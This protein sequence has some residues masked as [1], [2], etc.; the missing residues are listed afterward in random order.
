MRPALAP[1]AAADVVAAAAIA[2]GAP[3][4]DVCAAAAASVCLYTA[5][6]IQNDLFD[7]DRDKTLHPDRP[8][9]VDP[10]LA[11]KAFLL[12][13]VLIGVGMSLAIQ[14]GAALPAAIVVVLA[15]AYN[16]G[17]KKT[18]PADAITI[19][20]ARA[21]NLWIGLMVAGGGIQLTYMAGYLLFIG[22]ITSTSRAEDREPPPTRRLML[23][24]SLLPIALGV[25][26][27]ASLA[28]ESRA[29]FLL[30]G[31]VLVALFLRAF[32]D[33][34]RKATMRYVLH[35]LLTIFL[36]HATCLWTQG[37]RLALL[38]IAGLTVAS[39]AL[40]GASKP[41]PRP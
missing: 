29:L 12:T 3:V 1:T 38:P 24:L 32:W 11:S 19:G 9:I 28:T 31:G 7:R 6:M 13:L 25:G 41:A 36:V 4:L 16:L 5:G 23:M 2:G 33:G 21:A 17:L 39:I 27:F 37:H 20:G 30:P 14:A 34:T 26:A 15:S 40:L 10:S 22:G 18:F 35:M 8:L